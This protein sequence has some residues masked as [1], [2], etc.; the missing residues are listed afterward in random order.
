MMMDLALCAPTFTRSCVSRGEP[1][2]KTT[3]EPRRCLFGSCTRSSP[4]MSCFPFLAITTMTPPP[5]LWFATHNSSMRRIDF[6]VHPRIREWLRSTTLDLPCLKR[7]ILFR[8][9]S[10][11]TPSKPAKKIMPSTEMRLPTMR[12]SG[13]TTVECVPGSATKVQATQM[14]SKK[15]PWGCSSGSSGVSCTAIHIRPPMR[16]KNRPT[17]TRDRYCAFLLDSHCSSL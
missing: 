11:T 6:S 5:S 1:L 13:E 17:M 3:L 2:R 12:C 15:A 7:S 14:P 8:M 16:I 9:A 4:S 10:T